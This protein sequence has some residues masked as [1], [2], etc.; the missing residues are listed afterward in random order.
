M[1]FDTHLKQGA[2]GAWVAR[3]FEKAL[4]AILRNIDLPDRSSHLIEKN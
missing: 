1:L 3:L 4:R 2:T